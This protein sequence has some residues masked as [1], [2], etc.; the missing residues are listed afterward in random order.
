MNWRHHNTISEKLEAIEYLKKGNS[1]HETIEKYSV[2][3][4]TI[5]Y[6][7]DHE[8]KYLNISNK[9][10][11]HPGKIPIII[12]ARRGKYISLDRSKIIVEYLLILI[13]LM[14]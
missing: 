4:K 14:H 13:Y 12:I 2:D 1:I 9:K 6:W 8:K 3:K 11:L 10:A 7:I 5:R